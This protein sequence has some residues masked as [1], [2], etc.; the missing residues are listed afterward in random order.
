MS[1][2]AFFQIM[3][4]YFNSNY[5]HWDASAQAAWLSITNA[6]AA[7]DQFISYDDEHTCQ[8][9]V[10]YARNRH[11]GGVM[12]WELGQGYLPQQPV[13]ERTPLLSAIEQTL[14]T[15]ELTSI[16]LETQ[17][18]RLSFTTAPLA[19]YRVLWSSNLLAAGNNW[20]TLTSNVTGPSNGV[21]LLQI[22][23]PKSGQPQSFFRIQTP[24]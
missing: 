12:I 23:I 7:S 4:S 5:Y 3:A 16:Q 21:G 20:L 22:T 8:A 19:A 1:Q 9:K 10:S 24:P 14:A 15:P 2:V 18:V 11:L 6:S 13:G 17:Q